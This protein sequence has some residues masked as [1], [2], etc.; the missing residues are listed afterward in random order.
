[1]VPTDSESYVLK[2]KPQESVEE[3]TSE[4][5]TITFFRNHFPYVFS[6]FTMFALVQKF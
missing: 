5:L 2:F 1:M 3:V 4:F 6:L